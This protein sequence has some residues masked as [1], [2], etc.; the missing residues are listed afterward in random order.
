MY[1]DPGIWFAIVAAGIAGCFTTALFANRL[2]GV[3]FGAIVGNGNKHLWSIIFAIPVPLLLELGGM[4]GVFVAFMWLM[5]IPTIA[6]KT[7]FGPKQVPAMTL[8]ATVRAR[9]TPLFWRF[10]SCLR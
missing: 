4:A 3:A 8:D 9:P 5:A 6:S 10:R 7:Y 1:K 2:K